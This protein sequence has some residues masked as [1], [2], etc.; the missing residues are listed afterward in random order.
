MP[1]LESKTKLIITA[2]VDKYILPKTLNIFNSHIL[3]EEN[4]LS[5]SNNQPV[6]TEDNRCQL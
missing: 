3:S 4:H 5:T 1:H 2:S 6:L